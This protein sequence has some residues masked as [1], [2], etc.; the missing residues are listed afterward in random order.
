MKSQ[1]KWELS[2]IMA[3]KVILLKNVIRISTNKFKGFS[4]VITSKIELLRIILFIS[5]IYNDT[6]FIDSRALEHQTYFRK[7]FFQPLKFLLL[8]TN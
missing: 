4:H 5:M 3:L 1:R 6:W 7:K 2:I 8:V